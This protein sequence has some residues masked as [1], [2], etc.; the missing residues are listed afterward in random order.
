VPNL[1]KETDTYFKELI[2]GRTHIPDTEAVYCHCNIGYQN[3]KVTMNI[4]YTDVVKLYIEHVKEPT[5]PHVDQIIG[6]AAIGFKTI[7]K[8]NA[9]LPLFKRTQR[10]IKKVVKNV[11]DQVG[12]K[13]ASKVPSAFHVMQNIRSPG[14]L[15]PELAKYP[16]IHNMAVEIR[17]RLNFEQDYMGDNHGYERM[18]FQEVMSYNYWLQQTFESFNL[19]KMQLMPIYSVSRKHV[20]LDTRTLRAIFIMLFP[21]DEYTKALKDLDSLDQKEKRAKTEKDVDN[22]DIVMLPKKPDA[23]NKRRKDFT[24]EEWEDLK[25]AKAEFKRKVDEI[26]SSEEYKAKVK[27]YKYAGKTGGGF[28]NPDVFMLPK[29]P[30]KFKEKKKDCTDEEWKNIMKARDEHK[31]VV[32]QIRLSDEYKKQM[33]KYKMYTDVEK[34]MIRR[35]FKDLPIKCDQVFDCSILTD[36]ISVSLQFSKTEIKTVI[37]GEKPKKQKVELKAVEQYDTNLD[38][39][40]P[41]TGILTVGLDPGRVKLAVLAFITYYKYDLKTK[42]FVKTDKPV[43]FTK[44]LSRAQY[45]LDS[46]IKRLD[47]NRARRLEHFTHAFTMLGNN[48]GLRTTKSVDIIKYFW[49]QNTIIKEWWELELQTIESKDKLER[50]IGK[51]KVLDKFFANT[52]K[53]IRKMFN[54]QVDV[55]IVY[56][57]A[58]PT[59]SSSGK[60][61]L[62][63]PTTGTYK[64][65]KR[66]HKNTEIGSEI[67]S[68]KTRWE[69][70]KDKAKVYKTPDGR[71]HPYTSRYTPV[72]P[73]DKR[74][75]TLNW[76]YESY[77]KKERRKGKINLKSLDE[78]KDME[79]KTLRYPEV[80]GLRFCTESRKFHDRDNESAI[81]IGRLKIMAGKGEIP[82]CFTHRK[83]AVENV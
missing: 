14:D 42:M 61:E 50:Y 36:G 32:E 13:N 68:T 77:I 62:A 28:D 69:T 43:K 53:K 52:I 35:L 20:R 15:D 5:G 25:K 19:R 60:G 47:I 27:E 57:S 70:G 83:Q 44:G 72:V 46:G 74:D 76:M 34:I 11:R 6:Y 58:G 67:N 66:I 16:E 26:K 55:K 82:L 75:E 78:Y 31:R 65:C 45:R 63:V 81:A 3:E 18:S 1:Y 49:Q 24:A 64:A 9:Y 8:N 73:V 7:V 39:Y 29:I 23:F 2:R 4:T 59:M 38:M 71:V 37:F 41:N 51:R 17:Q 40:D 54:K 56:G 33:E 30:D 80:R 21:N 22:P 10:L 12:K 79:V 48:C